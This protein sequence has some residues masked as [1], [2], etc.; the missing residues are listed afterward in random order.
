MVQDEVE[1]GQ[2]TRHSWQNDERA[3][4]VQSLGDHRMRHQREKRAAGHSL[5]KDGRERAGNERDRPETVNRPR[6][7]PGSAQK[8]RA[9][10]GFG[11]AAD[12]DS[13]HYGNR[14]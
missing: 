2:E 14:K 12:E 1:G 5:G 8:R 4:L 13:E 3:S 11:N 6:W 7:K 9:R 10:R